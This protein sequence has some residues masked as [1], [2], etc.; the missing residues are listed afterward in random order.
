[1]RTLFVAVVVFMLVVAYGIT[2]RAQGGPAGAAPA[3]SVDAGKAV[4]ALGNTSC[5][6]CHGGDGEGA[7]GPA[8]AGRNLS[9]QRFRGYVRNPLGRMPA[10]IESELTDQEIA[11]LVVYFNSLQPIDK[12]S[13]WRFDLPQGAPRGQQLA[14]SVVGCAQCHGLTFE[15]PRHG[16]AEVNGDWEWFKRMVY[17]HT[18][19]QREQWGQLDPALPRVT[20][21]AAGPPGRNRVRMG[22]YLPARLPESMLREIYD[23]AVDLGSLVALSGSVTAGPGGPGGAT[24]TVTVVNTAV[25]NKGLAAED[26]TIAVELPDN[27]QVVNTTGA[28]YE[29]V[30]RNGE[31][32]MVATWRVPRLG[33]ADQQTYTITLSTPASA[34]RGTIRWGKPAVKA[35]E[36]VTFVLATGRGGRGGA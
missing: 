13:A 21:S 25:R 30:R 35:D 24:Y 26:V 19:A 23:W 29:G 7:F 4:W 33:P 1:M 22:N 12:P 11:D 5:R 27:A 17:Q 20:P 36:D 18:T 10:Y 6:N 31:G 14:V 15:T 32:K 2:G 9:Y 16:M 8:L 3:G 34:M 28:G